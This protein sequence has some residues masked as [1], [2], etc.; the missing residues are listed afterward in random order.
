MGWREKR[1]TKKAYKQS[2]YE[3]RL[4]CDNCHNGKYVRIPKGETWCYYVADMNLSE[5]RKARTCIRCGS[6]EMRDSKE[7]LGYGRGRFES[8]RGFY[9]RDYGEVE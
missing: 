6:L 8:P 5:L 4:T 3:V 9:E 7:F 2:T 1:A